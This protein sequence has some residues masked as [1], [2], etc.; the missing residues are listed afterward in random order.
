MWTGVIVG[1]VGAISSETWPT[2]WMML[3]INLMSFLP[4]VSLQT[5]TKKRALLY[6][7]VQRV[8]SLGVLMGGLLSTRVINALWIPL[9]LLLKMGLAPFQFWGC[10]FIVHINA[11]NAFF[12]LTLQKLAPISLLIV[13]TDKN[14]I[15]IVILINLLASTA[16]IGSKMTVLLLFFTR[17][18]HIGWVIAAPLVLAAK[19]YILYVIITIPLFMTPNGNDLSILILNMA[20]F[21]PITGFFMKIGV[22]QSIETGMGSLLLLFSIYHLYAYM[23]QFVLSSSV[24]GRTKLL[25]V[26]TCGYGL[27]V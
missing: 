18:M 3:E 6:F 23:R 14:T 24:F 27:L 7:I 15:T 5:R 25:T 13:S 2:I 19:Y 26:L 22:L 8:G 12:F 1:L 11:F 20:G 17:L 21:P 4:L 9:G 16:R 10:R